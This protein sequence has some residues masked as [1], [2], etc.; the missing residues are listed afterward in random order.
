MRAC[1][2][3]GGRVCGVHGG[4]G[5]GVHGVGGCIVTKD[6]LAVYR[7]RPDV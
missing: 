1:V 4:R 2:C 5:C 3:V 6:V 7:V